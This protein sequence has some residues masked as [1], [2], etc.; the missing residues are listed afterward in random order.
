M[1]A[2]TTS[3]FVGQK[4]TAQVSKRQTTTR[5]SMTVRAATQKMQPKKKGEKVSLSRASE[6]DSFLRYLPLLDPKNA[7]M[8]FYDIHLA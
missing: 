4:V 1:L 2:Q 3:T 8:K 6:E 7:K 5:Q